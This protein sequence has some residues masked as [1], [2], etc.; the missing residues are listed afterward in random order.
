MEEKM[1]QFDQEKLENIHFSHIVYDDEFLSEIYPEKCGKYTAKI[2]TYDEWKKYFT[3]LV[4][5]LEMVNEK[6]T[7]DMLFDGYEPHAYFNVIQYSRYDTMDR[8]GEF[9]IY[10]ITNADKCRE[11]NCFCAHGKYG[12]RKRCGKKKPDSIKLVVKG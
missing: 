4:R 12:S 3:L 7:V 11:D 2:S 5:I 8:E 1:E 9:E 10:I 6:V